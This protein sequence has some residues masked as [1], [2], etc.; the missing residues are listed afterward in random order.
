V[1]KAAFILLVI[2]G[3]YGCSAVE[4]KRGGDLSSAGIAY[5]QAS[6]R[7]IGVAMNSM[8]DADSET[9]V[10]TQLS[11]AALE[12]A[13][14]TPAKLRK[15]LSAS[16]K[17][18]IQNIRKM[19][20]LRSS[21]LATQA[22]FM[23][24]QDLVDNPQSD[25]TAD[26][27]SMMSDRVNLLNETMKSG[28]T[29][30]KPVMSDEQISALGGLTKLVA[31]EIHGKKVS[32]AMKRDAKIISES[33]IIQG[34]VLGLTE[35]IILG[36]LKDENARFFVDYVRA[37]F[38]IQNLDSRWVDNRKIYLKSK[39]LGDSSSAL[40]TARASSMHMNQTW[41]KI[42]SGVYDTREIRKQIE[43]INE[44]VD[45]LIALKDAEKPESESQT[46]RG[47]F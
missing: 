29:G 3:L 41:K 21:L 19:S 24:L 9:H 1:N 5:T 27:V 45:V 39:A 34:K 38:E 17:L 8:I 37:P 44:L 28:R 26:M 11:R 46:N 14:L 32:A 22:Y 4:V 42:L 36:A 35:K 12:R 18:L 43:E 25:T 47:A 13:G 30:V 16:D 23:A 15:R 7:L 40:N 10:R 20:N 2:Y 6:A 31:D 33:L